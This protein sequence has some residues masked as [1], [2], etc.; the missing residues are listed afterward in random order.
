MDINNYKT[1]FYT[2]LESK[3]GIIL[4][5]IEEQ[6]QAQQ[7]QAQQPQAQQPQAQQQTNGYQ[8]YKNS[9]MY[10]ASLPNANVGANYK[11]N[12][13][14]PNISLGSQP[15]FLKLCTGQNCVEREVK[16]CF[17]K[18]CMRLILSN[19]R[20][21]SQG[22]LQ[23]QLKPANKIA[24]GIMS[25]IPKKFTESFMTPQGWINFTADGQEV[26]RVVNQIKQATP[27]IQVPIGYGVYVSIV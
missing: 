19:V 26:K 9:L 12:S 22:D 20:L 17:G 15:G 6:T 18:R 21:N 7:P 14:L 2:L 23:A 4:P 24:Q 3:H 13:N 5:L 16:A 25:L 27:N 8:N 10:K 11:P 1:K